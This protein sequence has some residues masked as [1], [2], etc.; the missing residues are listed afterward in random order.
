MADNRCIGRISSV[1]G[2]RHLHDGKHR[3]Y[4]EYRCTNKPN[5]GTE[6]CTRC[7]GRTADKIQS[8]GKYDHG[9]MTGPIPDHSHIYG[10]AWYHTACTSWGLPSQDLI[11]LA[12]EHHRMA[13]EGIRVH[14]ENVVVQDVLPEIVQDVPKKAPRKVRI[15]RHT[16]EPKVEPGA[17]PDPT[18]EPKTKQ[19]RKKP[20]SAMPRN[21]PSIVATHIERDTEECYLDDYEIEYIK[22]SPFEHNGMMYLKDSQKN[23]LFERKQ[24]GVGNYIGRYDSYTET[25]RT[26]IPDSDAE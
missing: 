6:L 15:T 5:V 17:E 25:I 19:P 3:F 10:S 20:V 16:T 21:E 12:E 24:N 22:L 18:P 1:D 9:V 7:T 8:S 2:I 26:D 23:K 13:M 14:V 4:L 11:E